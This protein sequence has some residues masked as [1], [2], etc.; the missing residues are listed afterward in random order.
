[1]EFG[2]SGGGIFT[3]GL[4]W[5]GGV[6][7]WRAAAKHFTPLWQRCVMRAFCGCDC[8]SFQFLLAFSF[9]LLWSFF[10]ASRLQCLQMSASF[11][12]YFTVS[13]LFPCVFLLVPFVASVIKQST[14]LTVSDDFHQHRPLGLSDGDYL[15]VWVAMEEDVHK[16]SLTCVMASQ[17]ECVISQDLQVRA[18]SLV[19]RVYPCHPVTQSSFPN[20]PHW[21]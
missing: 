16:F 4:T 8:F 7:L 14:S 10:F 5:L 2:R 19:L 20:L 18:R 9:H 21:H 6:F 13:P 12:A 17:G 11:S 1:M 15:S 3:L